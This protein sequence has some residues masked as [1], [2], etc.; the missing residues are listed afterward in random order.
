MNTKWVAA[1]LV[2]LAASMGPASAQVAVPNPTQTKVAPQVP[3][4]QL[5][6]LED[7]TSVVVTHQLPAV[8]FIAR[9]AAVR[10]DGHATIMAV[11]PSAMHRT[12]F[13]MLKDAGSISRAMPAICASPPIR[14]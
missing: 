9:H 8:F 10:R 4:E 5:R 13:V 11:D 3:G 2:G 6:D 12:W 7:V 1:L 14:I